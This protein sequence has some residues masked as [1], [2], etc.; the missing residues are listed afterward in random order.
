[1]AFAPEMRDGFQI[2]ATDALNLSADESDKFADLCDRI[3]DG[4]QTYDFT[5]ARMT[6]GGH[7][8]KS[9]RQRIEAALR[10]GTRRV[11]QRKSRSTQGVDLANGRS[12]F[13]LPTGV[14]EPQRLPSAGV[15]VVGKGEGGGTVAN[16]PPV[17]AQAG[18]RSAFSPSVTALPPNSADRY[19]QPG[20]ND[21]APL[22]PNPTPPGAPQPSP[23]DTAGAQSLGAYD[24]RVMA[25]DGRMMPVSQMNDAEL[26]AARQMH[27]GLGN[28]RE[29]VAI[30]FEQQR[31]SNVTQNA[32]VGF[33]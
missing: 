16:V 29:V 28:G 9:T 12:A 27:M 2:Y 19:V 22:P 23:Q 32:P 30:Q 15:R 24:A 10:E 5:A 13:G 18:Y 14:S 33:A 25:T 8:I 31:R 6:G 21:I 26:E 20:S 1:M 17:G 11:R 7:Q 3:D 4:N